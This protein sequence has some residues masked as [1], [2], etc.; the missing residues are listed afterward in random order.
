MH[1]NIN[2]LRYKA[3][4][5]GLFLNSHHITPNVLAI[6][7]HA[8]QNQE[9]DFVQIEGYNLAAIFQRTAKGKGGAA[10]YLKPE[11]KYTDLPQ[12]K[13]KSI[14]S[15]IECV[16]VEASPEKIIII[17]VYRPPQG[18]VEIFLDTLNDILE[19][20]KN[21]A[22]KQKM[23]I[24]GDFNINLNSTDKKTS[25]FM[26]L[27][28]SHN[29]TPVINKS[30]R[31][32]KNT[33]TLIDNIFINE[34]PYI[35]A[36]NLDA[37]LSD[38]HAQSLTFYNK[39]DGN[40]ERLKK[41]F[42]HFSEKRL[43]KARNALIIQDWSDVLSNDDA[44]EAY[45][46]FNKIITSNINNYFPLKVNNRKATSKTWMTNGLK[47]SC[48]NKRLKWEMVQANLLSIEN[49]N[50]Y[51]KLLQKLIRK[52]KQ[53]NNDRYITNATNKTK[54]SWDV[55]K[56]KQKNINNRNNDLKIHDIKNNFIK[57][58]EDILNELNN[59]FIGANGE[60]PKSVKIQ[61]NDNNFKRLTNKS[62]IFLKPVVEADIVNTISQLN[63][64]RATGHDKIPVKYIKYMINEIATPLTHIL[65]TCFKTG[66]FPDI[67]KKAIVKPIFKKGDRSDFAN[68]RPIA[69]LSNVSKIFEKIMASQVNDFLCSSNQLSVAQHGFSKGKN[70][71]S[72]IINAVSD[73]LNNV[74]SRNQ[75]ISA[76]LDLTKAFDS[77]NYNT[78]YFK[79]EKYGLRGAALNLIQ[80]YLTG[81]FQQVTTELEDGTIATSEWQSTKRGVPQGSILG[82]YLFVIY[83]NDFPS[84]LAS[85]PATLYA[86]DVTAIASRT[87]TGEVI[88]TI[89][90]GFKTMNNWFELNDLALNTKKTAIVKY[91]LNP[92]EEEPISLTVLGELVTT[93]KT[94][95]FLGVLVDDKLSWRQHIRHIAA[96][97]GV[98]SYV[99]R[100]LHNEV[101][102]EVAKTAYFAYVHSRIEYGIL[103]W[104]NSSDAD[105]IKILQKKC[106]RALFNLKSRESC[107]PYFIAH[108]IPTVSEIY[109][110]Q[111]VI[112]AH[113]NFNSIR[114]SRPNHEHHTRQSEFYLP[115]PATSLAT[116]RNQFTHQAVILY[117]HLPDRIKSAPVMKF[118]IESKK[119]I[120]G[121]GIYTTQEYLDGSFN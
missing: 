86:D 76:H 94:A 109:I 121:R 61:I 90:E 34:F 77:L 42:R 85:F 32:T 8:L 68:Y 55:I 110:L 56:S 102:L 24:C 44:N 26:D 25:D 108:N 100:N 83:M 43:Q 118:K 93:V 96:K 13:N 104:G 113:K 91:S 19:L 2:S 88:A 99:L 70:T 50:N 45:N 14:E 28:N 57:T 64:T 98:F 9:S 18:S 106:V 97:I 112:H 66:T 53:M 59:F 39:A 7:E 67:L 23:C 6:T 89:E 107:K 15:Q 115:L 12:I 11:I 16:A 87:T 52:S 54:A 48:K 116:I 103:L 60:T 22:N 101:S 79:L 117:N 33:A 92:K 105:R 37:R 62:T 35:S 58:N 5:L 80:S 40:N 3:D 111:C 75:T 30:T 120:R 51:C 10:I 46:Y 41:L 4:E 78:L 47:T 114:C 72:A 74:D 119:L 71:I 21:K 65:N 84:D 36:G 73:I 27:L 95:N 69:I 82:P 81:R 29:L 63:N 1:L 17:C 38:H 31:I 49:Y 20:V